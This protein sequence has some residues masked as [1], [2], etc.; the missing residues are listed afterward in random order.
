MAEGYGEQRRRC[1]LA[2]PHGPHSLGRG[3]AQAVR[4][5]STRGA[6]RGRAGLRRT[7]EYS[8]GESGRPSSTARRC[9]SESCL[10]SPNQAQKYRLPAFWDR[11]RIHKPGEEQVSDVFESKHAEIASSGEV[12]D[13]RMASLLG[14]EDLKEM[15]L[16]VGQRNRLLHW[17]EDKAA[18]KDQK[19]KR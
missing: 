6:A 14:L 10:P 5:S 4:K 2:C 3:D 11:D 17:L 15:G 13:E 1:A 18:P 8:E 7:F 16:N 19:K 9:A 12:V